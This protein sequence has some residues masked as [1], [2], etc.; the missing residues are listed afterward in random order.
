MSINSVPVLSFV[1]R[2]KTGKTSL[3]ERLIPFF[4]A[5]GITVSV[6]KHHHLDFEIDIPGKDTY[7]FKQAGAR[8]VIISS[9]NKIA[10]IKDNVRNP[11][12]EDIISEYA[13]ETDV[14]IVEGY[15]KAKLPKIEV[16]LNR[17]NQP[18]VCIDDK[19]LLAIVTDLP[20]SARVPVFLRDDTEGISEFIFSHFAFRISH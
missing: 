12:I 9:P 6:I 1:G 14:V 18:P 5:K 10:I 17:E 8:T 16:Y 7:R 4:R 3:I 20:F 11:K 13:T 15:K 19:N 2:S